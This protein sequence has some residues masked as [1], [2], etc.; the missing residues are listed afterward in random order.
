MKKLYLFLLGIL[1]FYSVVVDAAVTKEDPFISLGT[2]FLILTPGNDN[3]VIRTWF[4]NTNIYLDLEDDGVWDFKYTK[5][6]GEDL[7]I[8]HSNPDLIKPG[9]RIHSDKPVEYSQYLG[10]YW[11]VVPE[12]RNLGKEYYVDNT[13]E[14]SL[15]YG[16]CGYYH[17]FHRPFYVVVPQNSNEITTIYVDYMDGTIFTVNVSH[18]SRGTIQKIT[19]QCSSYQPRPMR[20]YSNQSFYLYDRNTVIGPAG[21]DFYLPWQNIQ[22]L[23]IIKNNTEVKIDTNNDLNYDQT[24]IN[25]SGVYGPFS[26]AWGSH[27][28]SNNSI[29]VFTDW[30]YYV[31]LSDMTGNDI[32]SR[33]LSSWTVCWNQWQYCYNYYNNIIGLFEN[34]ALNFDRIKENDLISNFNFSIN[35]NEKITINSKFNDN[36][37][38]HI[39]AD[40]PFIEIS[41]NGDGIFPYSSISVTQQSKQKYLGANE[42]TT[43][44]VRIFNPFANTT[45]NNL[46]ATVRFPELFN[47]TNSDVMIE[48]R[49]IMNDTVIENSLVSVIPVDNEFSLNLSSL[50]PMQYLDIEYQLRTPLQIG[51]FEFEP[52]N[53]GYEAETWNMPG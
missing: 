14:S 51:S 8:T 20:I 26:L 22:K 13:P 45:I 1:L 10:S 44:E 21:N 34:T 7:E 37:R 31:Q 5:N 9:A 50:G 15:Y 25:D 41:N 48:K 36:S 52:V 38:F 35:Q 32:W 39:Y 33:D 19:V 12:I 17:Y 24:I 46:T 29:A 30:G 49:Y 2:D 28:H 3:H 40:K 6:S 27:I 16:P 4:N 11:G 53:I 47:W 42:T 18:L 23:I 43:M